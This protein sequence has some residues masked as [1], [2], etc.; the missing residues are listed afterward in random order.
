MQ[1][2]RDEASAVANS[3]R[4]QLIHAES[5]LSKKGNQKPVDLDFIDENIDWTVGEI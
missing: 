3:R 2:I 4:K 1:S 5:F